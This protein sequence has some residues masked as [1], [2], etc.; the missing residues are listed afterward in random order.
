MVMG[1]PCKGKG[2]WDVGTTPLLWSIN[3]LW[4]I[5]FLLLSSFPC[6][7]LYSDS[8]YYLLV[9]SVRSHGLQSLALARAKQ[10]RKIFKR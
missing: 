9:H 3:S 2:I 4:L 7:I 10:Q 1:W 8:H 6:A 5:L